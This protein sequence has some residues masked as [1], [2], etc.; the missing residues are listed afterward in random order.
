MIKTSA[1]QDQIKTSMKQLIKSSLEAIKTVMSDANTSDTLK[2]QKI[3]D[4]I[5]KLNSTIDTQIAALNATATPTIA[6][7]TAPTTIP[8]AADDGKMPAFFR[9][10]L[11]YGSKK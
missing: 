10:N 7:P 5:N 4:L 9:T 1:T 6:T 11:D 8:V 3:D 2:A